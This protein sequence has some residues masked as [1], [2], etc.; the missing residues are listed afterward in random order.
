MK[1]TAKEVKFQFGGRTWFVIIFFILVLIYVGT[2][3]QL[4]LN[5]ILTLIGI[6]FISDWFGE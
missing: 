1:T 2:Q 6:K 5:T 3:S 4:F